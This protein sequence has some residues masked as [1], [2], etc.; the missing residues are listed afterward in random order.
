MNRW[1]FIKDQVI[2]QVLNLWINGTSDRGL[3]FLIQRQELLSFG[4]QEMP[5]EGFGWTRCSMEKHCCAQLWRVRESFLQ[6][7]LGSSAD[8]KERKSPGNSRCDSVP[9][10]LLALRGMKSCELGTQNYQLVPELSM[11]QEALLTGSRDST[12]GKGLRLCQGKL[13]LDTMRN[14]FTERVV[15]HWC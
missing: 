6:P 4:E 9:N 14:F 15:Q 10:V 13:R 2:R 12:R 7:F 8:T 1:N 3:A 5:Q 11:E